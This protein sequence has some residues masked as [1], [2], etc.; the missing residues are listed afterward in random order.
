MKVF[1]Q[2]KAAVMDRELCENAHMCDCDKHLAP[3]TYQ[4]V[5]IDQ[6]HVD[7]EGVAWLDLTVAGATYRMPIDDLRKVDG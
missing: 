6:I 1:C 5:A 4:P 7:P 2:A 3:G